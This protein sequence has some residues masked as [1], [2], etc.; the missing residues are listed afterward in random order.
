MRNPEA[1]IVEED[2]VEAIEAR[3]AKVNRL[4][5]HGEDYKMSEALQNVGK[6]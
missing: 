5:R 3:E 6:K 4:A 2:I 1:A